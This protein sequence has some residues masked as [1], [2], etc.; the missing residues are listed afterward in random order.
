MFRNKSLT[1][2]FLWAI[3]CL[4]LGAGCS[5]P[6]SSGEVEETALDWGSEIPR[7]LPQPL[8]PQWASRDGM[9]HGGVFTPD[10][11]EFYWTVSDLAYERFEVL[12]SDRRSGGW[13]APRKA[14]FSGEASDHGVSF[15]PDGSALYFASTRP[16]PGETEAGLWRLWRSHRRAGGWGEPRPLEIPG[17]SDFWQSHGVVDEEGRLYFHRFAGRHGEDFDLFTANSAGSG[18]E[19]PRKLGP[20][21][22]SEGIEISP[23]LAPRGQWLFFT[24]YGRE[25]GFGDGDLYGSRRNPEG[26]WLP[27]QNLGS[28]VNTPREESNPSVT[29]DGEV[30]IFSR[31]MDP[32]EGGEAG[33]L[34]LRL[35]WIRLAPVLEALSP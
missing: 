21:V 13:S 7:D 19:A 5:P 33:T 32:P 15:S 1:F 3:L 30:L 4:L 27:A 12:E 23:F 26:G 18:F 29:P 31:R 8:F 28:A 6:P 9:E 22:N 14:F 2:P 24:A 35:H 34:P 17:S 25:D 10:G 11:M 16:L 20:E